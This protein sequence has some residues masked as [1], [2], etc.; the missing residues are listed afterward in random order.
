MNPFSHTIPL[1]VHHI[2]G[3]YLNNSESN[4]LL[5]CPNCHSLTD[6]YKA[7]NSDSSRERTQT[8][9][10]YCIDCGCEISS[11]S[12]RCHACNSKLKITEKPVSKDELKQLIRINTMTQIA[13]KFNVSTASVCHWCIYYGLPHRKKDIKKIF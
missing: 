7:L 3:N 5:L 6:N 9:K 13:E 11:N 2:D 1:D 8:R 4:L 12:L 10:Q